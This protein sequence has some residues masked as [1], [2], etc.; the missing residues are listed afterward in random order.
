VLRVPLL[1]VDF[2]RTTEGATRIGCG[3]PPFA[4]GPYGRYPVLPGALYAGRGDSG[5]LERGSPKRSHPLLV[6]EF[7][8]AAVDGT[9]A[10]RQAPALPSA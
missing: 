4:D 10:G 5:T 1:C 2:S 8:G 3:P 6:P 9:F 7:A